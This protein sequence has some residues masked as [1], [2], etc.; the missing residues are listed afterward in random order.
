MNAQGTTRALGI[1][2]GEVSRGTLKRG[3]E[4]KNMLNGD[5]KAGEV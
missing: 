5:Y 4:A 1:N 3:T 2:T